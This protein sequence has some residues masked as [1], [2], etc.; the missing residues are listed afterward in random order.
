MRHLAREALLLAA[1]VLT[2]CGGRD[3]LAHRCRPDGRTCR[4]NRKCCSGLCA[5]APSAKFGVC[6][7]PDCT[8]KECG[9]DGCGGSCGT[10]V[11]SPGGCCSGGTCQPGTAA[12]ACG[13]GVADCAVCDA[14]EPSGSVCVLGSTGGYHCGC[15]STADCPAASGQSAGRACLLAGINLCTTECN[16]PNVGPCNGGCCSGA[17][18]ETGNTCQ[19]GMADTAC[20][21]TGGTCVDCTT[22]GAICMNGTC[23]P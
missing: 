16:S 1:V 9:D 22:S 17:P 7:T 15:S 14:A 23:T 3:A 2:L 4:T 5:K 11:P 10:C 6:C 12:S 19:S 8:G 13:T 21:N 20:G 18:G